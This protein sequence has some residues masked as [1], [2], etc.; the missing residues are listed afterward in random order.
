M[1]Y[2]LILETII[3]NFNALIQFWQT[4]GVAVIQETANQQLIAATDVQFL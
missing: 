1:A 4:P 3:S 2:E